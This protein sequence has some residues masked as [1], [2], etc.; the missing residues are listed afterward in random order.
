MKTRRK[1]SLEKIADWIGCDMSEVSAHRYQVTR[2]D[3]AV[4]AFAD[5]Y[6]CGGK[7][8]P[9]NFGILGWTHEVTTFGDDVCVGKFQL[10]TGE[11]NL[12]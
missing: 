7:T 2:T 8:P 10:K 12:R 6:I 9:K 3:R 1:S 5:F 11:K 4:Y